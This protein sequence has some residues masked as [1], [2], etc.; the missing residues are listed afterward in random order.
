[1]IKPPPKK[2]GPKPSG[3]D[4]WCTFRISRDQLL[5]VEALSIRDGAVNTSAWLRALIARELKSR[6]R[7]ESDS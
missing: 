7:P 6:M 4:T 1:M 2:R 5:Q 3:N